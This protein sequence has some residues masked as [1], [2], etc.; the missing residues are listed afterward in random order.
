MISD[1]IKAPSLQETVQALRHYCSERKQLYGIQE[2]A[3]TRVLDALEKRTEAL[4]WYA[5]NDIH[6][7]HFDWSDNGSKARA[8]L[9]EK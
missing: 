7:L 9:E 4:K 8:A 1:D 3:L 2:T 5:T 6:S